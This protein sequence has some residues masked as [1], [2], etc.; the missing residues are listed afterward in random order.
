MRVVVAGVAAR[1]AGRAFFGALAA[2]ARF[3]G[4][5]DSAELSAMAGFE[6]IA[7]F[8]AG[9]G[10]GFCAG[11][12]AGMAGLDVTSTGPIVR[13]SGVDG[14]G[15]PL[16]TSSITTTVAMPATTPAIVAAARR[17]IH[18]RRGGGGFGGAT[19]TCRS[20][21]A[22]FCLARNASTPVRVTGGCDSR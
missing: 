19:G 7:G 6:T 12:V 4:A 9:F 20:R 8:G 10:A 14:A 1:G 5:A 16:R 22:A 17:A 11:L 15:V 3:E 18:E 2:T 13:A 21:A